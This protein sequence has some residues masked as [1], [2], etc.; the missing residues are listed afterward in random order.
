[1]DKE[2]NFEEIL[3]AERPRLVRLCA[4]LSGSREAAEDLTQEVLC[5]AWRHADRLREPERHAPWLSSIARNVCLHWSRR[6]Y[7]EQS[8]LI[9]Q[10]PTEFAA[11]LNDTLPDRFDLE[12]ELEREE[13][14]DLLDRA[15][16]MLPP[17]TRTALVEHYLEGS[18]HAEIA[19][20]LGISEGAVAVRLHRGKLALRRVLTSS[21]RDEAAAYGM[22]SDTES[23]EETRIWCPGC[24]QRRLMGR[25]REGETFALRC[26]S[27]DARPGEVMSEAKLSV[28]FF[29]AALGEV[30]SYKPAFTRFMTALGGYY[31]QAQTRGVAP[32]LMCGRDVCLSIG[33]RDDGP[34]DPK[35][36]YEARLECGA[37]GWASNNSLWGLTI[38]LP[39]AQRLWRVNPRL[40]GLPTR[41]VEVAGSQAL[42]QRLQSVA[43]HAGLDVVVLRHNF[44]V[45]QVHTTSGT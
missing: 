22:I 29:A 41:E 30:R 40:R 14:A 19:A 17:E 33:R 26:P 24:A 39:E 43:G 35:D 27:C 2:A 15:L 37:C 10:E 5:A 16:A 42:V 44:E 8:R 1:M 21:L 38:S 4:R 6:H 25:F 18:P 45:I 3:T 11:N 13:L 20:R 7:R 12:V 31:R 23:W 9:G 34:A 36:D 32:C 28:P